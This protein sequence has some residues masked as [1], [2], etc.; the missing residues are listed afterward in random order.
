MYMRATLV[1]LFI[2]SFKHLSAETFKLGLP[3]VQIPQ[4]LSESNSSPLHFSWGG[5]SLT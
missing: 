4:S 1:C 5:F 3:F 2:R